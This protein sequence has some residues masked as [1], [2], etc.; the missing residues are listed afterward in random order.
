VILKG[1]TSV[2]IPVYNRPVQVKNAIESSVSQSLAPFEIIVVDDGSTDSTLEEIKKYN[3]KVKLITIPRRGVSGARNEGIKKAQGEY[4]AFL[5]SDDTWEKDKLLIQEKYLDDNQSIM[6]VHT[7]ERWIKNGRA[8]NKPERYK[9]CSGDIFNH[10]LGVTGVGASTLMTRR[11][12]FLQTGLFDEDMIVCEDNDLWLRMALLSDIGYI[13]LELVNKY[14]GHEGQLSFSV[15]N[16]DTYRVRSLVKLLR[17]NMLSEKRRACVLEILK[18]KLGYIIS[19]LSKKN[20][21]DESEKYKQIE[22]E[23]GI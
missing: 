12:F 6:W 15:P 21:S 18:K 16:Q 2:I 8:V 10:L 4:V 20:L 7:D 3:Q 9:K 23:F 5:D 22:R 13:D 1:K 14:A 17:G 11:D 19:A